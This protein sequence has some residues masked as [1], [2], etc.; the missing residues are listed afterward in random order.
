M[1]YIT[2]YPDTIII[3][4]IYTSDHS[5]EIPADAI[6]LPDVDFDLINED[7]IGL[8]RYGFD[9]SNVIER[10]DT[11]QLMKVEEINKWAHDEIIK[12][13]PEW[14]QRNAT[15]RLLELTIFTNSGG[16]LTTAESIEVSDITDIWVW[17]KAV[18]D[19]SNRVTSMVLSATSV[20][21]VAFD[22]DPILPIFG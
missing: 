21:D 5:L 18:R 9:G 13:W 12:S 20:S 14:K 2:T 4:G 15:A 22:E 3:Q 6:V 8:S 7:P 17:I 19:E 11:K 10:L 1:Y 16:T